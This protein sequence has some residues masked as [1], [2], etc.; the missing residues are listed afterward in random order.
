MMLTWLISEKCLSSIL[1][2]KRTVK[3]RRPV[4]R[5]ER[6]RER[7][8][9]GRD[10]LRGAWWAPSG[11]RGC[12]RWGDGSHLHWALGL[13]LIS[14]QQRAA[15]VVLGSRRASGSA[16]CSQ[17]ARQALVMCMLLAGHGALASPNLA[18]NQSRDQSIFGAAKEPMEESSHRFLRAQRMISWAVVMPGLQGWAP[19]T[20]QQVTKADWLER[21]IR[22]VPF[23]WQQAVH[24]WT[25]S[26]LLSA[27]VSSSVKWDNNTSLVRLVRTR[28]LYCTHYLT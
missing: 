11:V 24:A 8:W 17:G 2:D 15:E 5:D 4:S 23:C 25:A 7:R 14:E 3:S 1:G 19:H 20:S 9:V 18:G 21:I 6:V 12:Q 26:S 28:W 10:P 27:L 13:L 16:H 22:W